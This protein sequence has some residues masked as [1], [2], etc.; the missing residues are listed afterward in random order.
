MFLLFTYPWILGER[1][2]AGC[3][4]MSISRPF[5]I[6]W[7]LATTREFDQTTEVSASVER[8]MTYN[9]FYSFSIFHKEHSLWNELQLLRNT[10]TNFIEIQMHNINYVGFKFFYA[11]LLIK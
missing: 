4:A 2:E 3:L 9:T 5:W 10:K 8:G 6:P 1:E 11:H 7:A